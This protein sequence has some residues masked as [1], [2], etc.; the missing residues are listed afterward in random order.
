MIKRNLFIS[1]KFGIKNIILFS[2]F[3]FSINS[4][5][6]K[7]S[8]KNPNRTKVIGLPVFF[9]TPDTKIGGGGA[10]LL[11]FNFKQDSIRA[12]R[13]SVTIGAVYT[14]L[15]QTLLY[16]PF[17]LF[18]QN[19]KYWISGELGYFKYVFNFFG[20]GNN[21][22]SDY[23]EKYDATFPRIRLN[24]SKKI[25][26]NL[27]F[28]FRYAFDNFKFTRVQTD[29]LLIEGKITGSKGGRVSGV[30][31]QFNYDS[32]DLLFFPR[33]GW[34]AETFLYVESRATGSQFQYQRFSADVTRYFPI[35][36]ESVI[37]INGVAVLSLGDVP[38]HQMP[39][40]GGTKRLR[41]YFEGKYRDENMLIL[42]S[43]WRFPVYKR[44]GG[45]VFGGVGE[46]TDKPLAWR[47]SNVRY[48]F[49]GGL[50]FTL[51]KAQHINIRADYGIGYRSQGFYLT[52]G[53]AF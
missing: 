13:S 4:H 24:V 51:D 11:T 12:R 23:I 10:A 1:F 5:A 3:L 15:N 45:V 53:E 32:R 49:G 28:G 14:Q 33:K 16:F 40:I 43:E 18:P 41:G 36:K 38:F 27:F 47:F 8:L 35:G 29:G 34:V 37:A 46:V 30:G 20:V 9:Y 6:Q 39:V 44:F 25:G 48:N 22:P 2:S 26:Q 19:Q 17:Q 50:R 52:F 21:T 42:Q 7:D 31:I